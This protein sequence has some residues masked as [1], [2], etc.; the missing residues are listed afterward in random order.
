MSSARL[1]RTVAVLVTHGSTRGIGAS[2]A[3][4][5]HQFHANARVSTRKATTKPVKTQ[6]VRLREF[7][8]S[9]FSRPHHRQPILT[10]WLSLAHLQLR[11]A[12]QNLIRVWN[13]FARREAF[14]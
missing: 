8:G 9:T 2:G 6:V 11:L 3:S 14:G 5:P 1:V 7:I 10:G 4:W 13:V 12:R